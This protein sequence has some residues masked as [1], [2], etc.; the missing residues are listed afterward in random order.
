MSP[1]KSTLAAT[2]RSTCK[3]PTRFA[4]RW[5]PACIGPA[6]CCPRCGRWPSEMH[7]NPNTVQ[8][9]YDALE[10]EGLVYSQRGRGLFVAQRGAALAQSVAGDGVRRAFDEAIRAGR[11]VRHECGT[12]SGVFHAA[13]QRRTHRPATGG[14]SVPP[15]GEASSG[16]RDTEQTPMNCCNA[17]RL[18]PSSLSA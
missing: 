15:P 3:S 6:R 18:R 10:R 17:R 16:T 8:R 2:Y 7:V 13:L 14:A 1:C 4:R 11:V 5:R 12:N 9:A